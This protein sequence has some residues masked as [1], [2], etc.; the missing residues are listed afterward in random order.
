MAQETTAYSSVHK[1]LT[2]L[3]AF[4][5][6][7]EEISA[8]E[9]SK[10]VGIHK[11][12]TTRLLATLRDR[13]YLQQNPANKKFTLGFK[14]K[15]LSESFENSFHSLLVE[16]SKPVIDQLRDGLGESIVLAIPVEDGVQIIYISEGTGPIRLH[17]SI[18]TVN[19]YNTGAGGK[20]LLAFSTV[21]FQERIIN[22]KL[23]Q[24]TPNSLTDP[25]KL[26][27]ELARIVRQEYAVDREENHLGIR[28]IAVPI[29]DQK[30]KVIATLVVAGSAYNVSEEKIEFLA[31][32]LKSAVTKISP[33]F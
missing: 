6:G 20:L 13:G 2:L 11:S 22:S 33:I 28:G 27:T 25:Q 4:I 32:K 19:P 30:R 23:K 10:T 24:R 3:E 18:G 5:P 29:F 9:L 1:A 17:A 14:I 15:E 12:T 8:L 26:K 7:N 16:K 31:E 21:D